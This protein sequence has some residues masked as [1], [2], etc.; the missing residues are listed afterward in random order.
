MN[1]LGHKQTWY[2]A[3]TNMSGLRMGEVVSLGWNQSLFN[4][5]SYREE[6]EF[7]YLIICTHAA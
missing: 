2:H 7:Y 6:E 5:L 3:K 1:Q 4:E